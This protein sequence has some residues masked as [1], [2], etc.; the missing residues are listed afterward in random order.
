VLKWI[1]TALAAN[2]NSPM[3]CAP[4]TAASTGRRSLPTRL[5]CLLLCLVTWRGPLPWI[6]EHEM[7][8]LAAGDHALAEH[9]ATYHAGSH[10]HGGWHVHVLVPFGRCP[11][12]EEREE[13]SPLHDPLSYYGALAAPKAPAITSAH[14]IAPD[15][16]ELPY[17][18]A[19]AR[20]HTGHGASRPTHPA[21]S[22][23][24]SLLATAPLRAVTG[25][26]LC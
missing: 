10:D 8:P 20:V 16:H 4:S 21:A 25:V 24:G 13:P 2:E 15:W 22:F 17:S 12:G 18:E 3:R 11:C 7:D 14:S 5:T 6:H 26:A 19:F 23:L 9:L 1:D